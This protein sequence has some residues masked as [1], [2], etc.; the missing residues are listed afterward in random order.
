[1]RKR[2]I[3][4]TYLAKKSHE[5]PSVSKEING[6]KRRREIIG[7]SGKLRWRKSAK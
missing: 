1:M 4:Q 7:E 6:E 5:K 3:N 2:R